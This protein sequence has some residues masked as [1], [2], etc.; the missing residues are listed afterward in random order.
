MNGNDKK[1]LERFT[2]GLEREQNE[3][4]LIRLEHECKICQFHVLNCLV[5]SLNTFSMKV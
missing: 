4:D 5:K 3:T 1:Y 2:N